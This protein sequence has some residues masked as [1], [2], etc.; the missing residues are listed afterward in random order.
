MKIKLLPNN[1][2]LTSR[3]MKPGV[4]SKIFDIPKIAPQIDSWDFEPQRKGIL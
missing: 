3:P 2:T 4:V 1:A